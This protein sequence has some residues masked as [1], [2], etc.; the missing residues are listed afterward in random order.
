MSFRKLKRSCPTRPAIT[1]KKLSLRLALH[2][3]KAFKKKNR[4]NITLTDLCQRFAIPS[5]ECQACWPMFATP[6]FRQASGTR[7]QLWSCWSSGPCAWPHFASQDGKRNPWSASPPQACWTHAGR[8]GMLGWKRPDPSLRG[9]GWSNLASKLWLKK[10]WPYFGLVQSWFGSILV[11][12]QQK[13]KSAGKELS[14][15]GGLPTK[16]EKCWQRSVANPEE[17]CGAPTK[18]SQCHHQNAECKKVSV[19]A[20]SICVVLLDA[21]TKWKASVLLFHLGQSTW[22][23]LH[24]ACGVFANV[25]VS[26]VECEPES[27]D[28]YTCHV[29]PRSKKASEQFWVG[30]IVTSSH[31]RTFELGLVHPVCN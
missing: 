17:A 24:L 19:L 22:D 27:M 29:K 18:A 9:L 7:N 11:V 25:F 5:S 15:L 13:K 4:K 3:L 26:N 6:Q 20:F 2:M 23:H 12:Y 1:I 28:P 31:S 30:S 21:K 14:N 16:K 8:S 10:N